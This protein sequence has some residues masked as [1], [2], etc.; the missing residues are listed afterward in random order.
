MSPALTSNSSITTSPEVQPSIQNTASQ[1]SSSGSSASTAHNRPPFHWTPSD[2]VN[3]ANTQPT[4]KPTRSL[5]AIPAPVYEPHP[6]RSDSLDEKQLQPQPNDVQRPSGSRT[7]SSLSSSSHSWQDKE[8]NDS[9][10][11]DGDSSAELESS[12]LVPPPTTTTTNTPTSNPQSSSHHHTRSHS[13]SRALP[14]HELIDHQRHYGHRVKKSR[15]GCITI[16]E[17]LKPWLPMCAWFATTIGFIIALAFWR[18]QVF[19]GMKK[20]NA[21]SIE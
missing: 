7:S 12:P 9:Y 18:K 16:P 4:A 3:M 10:H 13:L 19:Q 14:Q 2:G 15:W 1:S 8:E 20:K 21:C 6:R 11:D 17:K 5:R